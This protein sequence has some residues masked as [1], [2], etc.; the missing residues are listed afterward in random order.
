MTIYFRFVASIFGHIGLL[1]V[2]PWLVSMDNN[3]AVMLGFVLL[4]LGLPFLWWLLF[5]V[6]KFLNEKIKETLNA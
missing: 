2:V 1:I 6:L 4:A 3:L 5:P